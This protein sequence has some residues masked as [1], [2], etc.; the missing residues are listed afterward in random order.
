MTN[1]FF[2]SKVF[3]KCKKYNIPLWQ[4]PEFLFLVMGV[5]IIIASLVFYVIGGRYVSDP[6]IVALMVTIITSFL[7]V[8]SFIITNS[9][10]KL[11][12]ADRIKSEFVGIASHQLRAPLTNLRWTIQFLKSMTKDPSKEGKEEYFDIIEENSARMEGLINDLL[13]VAQLET[14]KIDKRKVMFSLPSLIKDVVKEQ[15]PFIAEKN[16]KIIQEEIKELPNVFASHALIKIVI[17]NLINNAISYSKKGGE[18][19]I[20]VQTKR[21]NI[22]FFIEDQGIGIPEQDKRYIFQKFFRAKNAHIEE[23]SGTGLGLFI[24]KMIMEGMRGKIWF[25][26]QENK[27]TAFYFTLPIINS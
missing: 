8:I 24:V 25:E 15:G 11:A 3:K 13:I 7:L 17:E 4:C 26:S 23:V 2:C 5:V 9:F 22:L 6:R 21:K 18:I 16:L 19:K 1:K 20:K 12:E 27:G 14:G 10:E